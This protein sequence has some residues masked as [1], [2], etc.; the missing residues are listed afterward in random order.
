MAKISSDAIQL[1][2]IS[3]SLFL[4]KPIGIFHFFHI[5]FIGLMFNTMMR[6]TS[7]FVLIAFVARAAFSTQ[8]LDS[9]A[10]AVTPAPSPHYTTV[11]KRDSCT[12]SGSD[13][14]AEASKSRASCATIVLSDVAVPSG[15]TLDLSKLEDGTNV[16]LPFYYLCS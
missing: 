8:V 4:P 6:Q 13:G 12:F 15:T 2:Y 7:I 3:Q 9:A 11:Q 5:F 16:S 14:A 1:M 10:P